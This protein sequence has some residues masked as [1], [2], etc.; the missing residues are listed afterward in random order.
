MAQDRA[1]VRNAGATT[2][3]ALLAALLGVTACQ[4]AVGDGAPS[5]SRGDLPPG[6]NPDD[7]Q[8]G[9]GQASG[10]L[11]RVLPCGQTTD[12]ARAALESHCSG[13]HG[14]ES[15]GKGGFDTVEDALALIASGKIVAGDAAGS[16]LFKKMAEGLMPPKQVVERPSPA[17]L[18][19]VYDWISCGAP[20]WQSEGATSLPFVDIDTR[21]RAV[22]DDLRS[23]P[24]PVDR[25]RM[26]Y[27]DLS[28]LANAGYSNNQLELYRESVFFLLNSLSRGRD[29][30]APRAIDESRLIFRIDMRDYLWTAQ[31]WRLMEQSYPYA[32]VYNNN[33][34]LFPVDEVTADQIRE[35]TGSNIPIIQADWMLS[36]A[37]RPPLYHEMLQL[38][39]TLA[40]VESA[41]GVNID[42]DVT[43]EQVLR[44]GFAN[45]A[46]SRNHGVIERHALEGN[47]GS[48]W[49]AYDFASTL[50]ERNVFANPFDFQFDGQR[51][52]FNLDNGLQAY[53]VLDAAGNRIDKAPNALVQDPLARDGAIE[54]GSSCLGCHQS[55]GIIE[56]FDEVRDFMLASG[57]NAQAI[58]A[59]LGLY[60]DR[61][62]MAEAFAADRELYRQA[63]ARLG[64]EHLEERTMRAL[65]N[66]HLGLM[67]I[68]AAAGVLGIQASELERALDASGG[69]FP[70]EFRALRVLGGAIQRDA[71]DEV[72]DEVVEVLGLGRALRANGDGVVPRPVIDAGV[73]EEDAGVDPGAEL[74]AGVDEEDA[75]VDRGDA[76]A[77]GAGERDA[78]TDA[79]VRRDGGYSR[80]DGGTRYWP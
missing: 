79:Q 56:K 26:R 39:R 43:G 11:P 29:V 37:S 21:L 28:T 20:D 38:P 27:V 50:G 69:S 52:I 1:S 75:G 45:S 32:I 64:M 42:D 16:P 13:C 76:G 46:T 66:T 40:Q 70:A 31:T 9:P 62:S 33:S 55:Q 23:L 60:S 63:R 17:E 78:S 54:N 53:L 49:I 58:E 30:I 44:A 25:E 6:S 18:K 59:A 19:A 74:D 71:F 67:D 2:S 4:N 65:D 24:N 68:N 15:S 36:H 22:L 10:A 41:L 48:L 7:P 51:V 8:D 3:A 57:P 72:I 77:G 5:G 12:K 73:D 80:S 34:R 35:Q 14:S 47:R 61:A